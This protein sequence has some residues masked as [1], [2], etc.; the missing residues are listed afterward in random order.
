MSL[1]LE[2]LEKLKYNVNMTLFM[3][4]LVIEIGD[5]DNGKGSRN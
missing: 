2:N 3:T 5:S 1:V 4:N